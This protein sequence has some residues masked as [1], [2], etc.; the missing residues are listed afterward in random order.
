MK[1]IKVFSCQS[2]CKD[3]NGGNFAGIVLNQDT[4][5]REGMQGIATYLQFPETAFIQ[6]SGHMNYDFETLFFT[7]NQQIDLC[8]HATIAAYTLMRDLGLIEKKI[9]THNT[10]AGIL[11]IDVKDM[12]YA[13]LELPCFHSIIED[14]IAIADSLGLKEEEL[15]DSIPIQIVSTGVKDI[16]IPVKSKEK[17]M[18]IQANHEKIKEISDKYGVVGYHVFT[19][20]TNEAESMAHCRNFAPLYGIDEEAAT[21]T[22]N[23]ALACYLY[24]YHILKDTSK[25]IIFEQGYVLDNPSEVRVRL[26]TKGAAIKKVKI[27][28]S[29]CNVKEQ[30]ITI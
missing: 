28:G 13:E 2:F 11:E 17:L 18:A 1:K 27:G 10:M 23:S 30:E 25:D 12:I 19:L 20:D 14:K 26:E 24:Q 15:L 7:P 29:I 22:S 9:Y 16:F 8:G 5:P 4:L 21:G 3:N 6:K